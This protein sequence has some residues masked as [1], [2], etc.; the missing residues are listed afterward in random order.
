MIIKVFRDDILEGLQK[1]AAIIPAKT[2]AAYLRTIWLKGEAGKLT[3]MATDSNLE[4]CGEYKA[5]ILEEGLAGVQ[6]RAF[7]DLVRKLPAGEITLKLKE[8][9]L[10]V[11]QGT[12]TYKLPINEPDWFQG[13]AQFPEDGAVMWAGDVLAEII[14]RVAY[15][16]SDEDAMEAIACMNLVAKEE[17]GPAIPASDDEAESGGPS[18]YVEICGLNGHQFAMV[19]V[20]NDDIVDLL[21]EGGL[22]L[23]KKYVSELKKWLTS[24]EIELA[25]DG[26][27]LF[28]RTADKEESFSL[29]LSFYQY[30]DYRGFLTKVQGDEGTSTMT[31]DRVEM[32]DSLDRILIFNSDTNK[33]VNF[34]L[35]SSELTLAAQ[36]QDVGTASESLA[37]DFSGGLDKIAFPTRSLIEILGHL[38]SAK[39]CFTFTGA[40]GPCG[41]SGQDDTDYLV[42]LMPMKVVEETYYSEEG[43]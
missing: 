3:I 40:E 12:R 23:Q 4:F 37:V 39:V 19:R 32:L 9:T 6:G 16:I 41:I 30:P 7:Y 2:G 36:G 15:C 11:T 26:K 24:E 5:E 20:I 28:C 27:R 18:R 10:N 1:S 42:V 14:E 33:C 31:V 34:Q 43:N 22:L 38:N 35:N 13:L 8:K 17:T 21:P 25:L 29:P